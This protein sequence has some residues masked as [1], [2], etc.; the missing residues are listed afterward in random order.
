MAGEVDEV[1]VEEEEE[2]AS[3]AEEGEVGVEGFRGLK[4][5]QSL[6]GMLLIKSSVS[7]IATE[8]IRWAFSGF[9]RRMLRECR[10][11][12]HASRETCFMMVGI[13]VK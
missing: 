13:L 6:Y 3:G 1:G 11:A 9:A 8:A 2:E 4:D 10:A 7:G 5:Y 12:P